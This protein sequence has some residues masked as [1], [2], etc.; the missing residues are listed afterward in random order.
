[1]GFNA[2]YGPS[3][4]S[5]E[6]VTVWSNALAKVMT[7]PSVREQLMKQ[8]SMPVGKGPEDLVDRGK[9]A[10]ARWAPIIKE[11]GFVGD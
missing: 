3:G 11:S 7:D 4:V 9:N 6:I 2:L 1:M 8:G 10:S 5:K